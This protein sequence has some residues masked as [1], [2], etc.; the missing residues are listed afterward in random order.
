MKN[1]TA[2]SIR[3]LLIFCFLSLQMTQATSQQKNKQPRKKVTT[4]Q[5]SAQE[6]KYEIVRFYR[7]PEKSPEVIRRSYPQ[8]WSNCGEGELVVRPL[9]TAMYGENVKWEAAT[10]AGLP[11]FS[12]NGSLRNG[13]DFNS[14]LQQST[15]IEIR[16]PANSIL[17]CVVKWREIREFGFAN[18]RV[19][20]I[21]R[22]LTHRL[23]YV[24]RVESEGIDNKVIKNCP[25]L[26]T[27]SIASTPKEAQSEAP[28]SVLIKLDEVILKESLKTETKSLAFKVFAD[29]SIIFD[30][31]P[32]IITIAG[33]DSV[34]SFWGKLDEF[35]KVITLRAKELI[36]EVRDQ[37]TGDSIKGVVRYIENDELTE[38]RVLQKAVRV[39]SPTRQ[40]YEFRFTL[41][42]V[43]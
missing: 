37:T 14:W 33:K 22:I 13:M 9:N 20:G 17:E 42:L 41:T 28:K 38:K 19:A 3:L 5:T 11:I 35:S 26:T 12:L 4:S 39:E 25:P 43:E 31:K 7:D 8:R 23:S 16:V 1:K 36:V 40:S 21:D 30:V 27:S 10:Q 6:Q 24:S 15:G 32:E 29:N 2:L 18:V 34:V